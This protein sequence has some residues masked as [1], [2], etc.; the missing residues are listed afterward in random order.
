MELAKLA[1][2]GRA[3]IAAIEAG[4]RP[5]PHPATRARLAKALKAKPE[6]LFS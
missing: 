2:V 1:D 6:D 4:K 3:A 5:R